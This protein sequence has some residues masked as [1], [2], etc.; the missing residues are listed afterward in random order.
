MRTLRNLAAA[1]ATISALTVFNAPAFAIS[2]QQWTNLC[3]NFHGLRSGATQADT[4]GA[5]Y[6][7]DNGNN[8]PMNCLQPPPPNWDNL[9]DTTLTLI[10]NFPNSGPRFLLIVSGCPGLAADYQGAFPKCNTVTGNVV[11]ATPQTLANY[12]VPQLVN[13]VN[14]NL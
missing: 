7:M 9:L 13:W 8:V 1:I 3:L 6:G 14:A 2:Q 10:K 4:N 5:G 11:V 12:T